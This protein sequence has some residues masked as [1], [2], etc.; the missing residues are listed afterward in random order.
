MVTENFEREGNM[1]ETPPTTDRRR[2]SR[3]K[4]ADRRQ[5]GDRRTKGRRVVSAP[6]AHDRRVQVIRTQTS[7]HKIT[8]GELRRVVSRLSQVTKDNPDMTAVRAQI[9]G[10]RALML[11]VDPDLRTV[12]ALMEEIRSSPA[13]DLPEFHKAEQ[14]LERIGI[15][16]Q[17]AKPAPK[18]PSKKAKA[19]EGS[20]SSKKPS[21]ATRGTS[22]KKKVTKKKATKKRASKKTTKTEC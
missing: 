11:K 17:P 22:T 8:V 4:I 12:G 2:G 16:A 5:P 3:R 18:T 7:R 10:A 14:L 1:E 19:A 9:R 13:A 6:V 21:T 15:V 20:T